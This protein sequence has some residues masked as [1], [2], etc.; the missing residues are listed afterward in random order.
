MFTTEE[1]ENELVMQSSL[2]D[3][4]VVSAMLRELI[5]IKSQPIPMVL[6][7]PSCGTQH[8]DKSKPCDMGMNCEVGVCYASA[9]GEP[10]RCTAWNNPPHRSHLCHACGTIWR[11]A[12]VAT[13]GVAAIQTHGKADKIALAVQAQW[14]DGVV[15]DEACAMLRRKLPLGCAG[16]VGNDEARAA[17]EAVA[18]LLRAPA[19]D[20]KTE[21]L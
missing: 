18:P 16:M 4:E 9:M 15:S 6:H 17:L 10:E 21:P 3:G 11:P 7:C 14:G 2:P 13:V 1:I 19:V 5:Q 8:I 20:D 12:D